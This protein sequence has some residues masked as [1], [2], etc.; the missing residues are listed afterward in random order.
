MFEYNPEDIIA[1]W[2]SSL[3][4]GFAEGSF[5]NGERTEDS[6]TTHAGSQGDVTATINASKQ[7]FVTV[8]VVQGSPSNAE[9]YAALFLQEKTG[10]LQKRPFS[11][12]DLAGS[13]LVTAPNAW[14]RKPANADFAKEQTNRTWIFDCDKLLYLPGV[15]LK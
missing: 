9:L 12:T 8:I 15:A 2:G 10:K 4:G 11:I 3:L 1:H 14:I 13:I 6:V 7:G 5:V